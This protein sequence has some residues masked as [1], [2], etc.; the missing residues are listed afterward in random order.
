MNKRRALITGISGFAGSFLAEH[1]L[2]YGWEVM[3]TSP[4]GTWDPWSPGHI[5]DKV[6]LV[7]WDFRDLAGLTS[8]TASA[9]RRFGPTAIFHLAALSIPERC[10]AGEPTAEA[11][12]VNVEG[13][14]QVLHLATELGEQVPVLV[15][16]SSH[17]YGAVS[18]LSP[19]VDELAPLA[20]QTAYAK[21][22]HAVERLALAVAERGY[23]VVI[24][25]AFHHTGPRQRP[26][27]LLPQWAE[28]F[29][30]PTTTE[31]VVY[32]L[33]VWLDLSDVR[34]VVCAYRLLIEGKLTG[35]FNVGSGQAISTRQL[36]ELM[37][38]LSGRNLPVREIRPGPKH[39]PIAC[40][41]RLREATGWQPR[42][43]LEQTVADVL[44]WWKNHWE[45]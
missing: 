27:M 40:I 17:V 14:R 6:P 42:I 24:A 35:V 26:P 19:I 11:W 7:D 21:T 37:V 9:I 18:E 29:A 25:R 16:S 30:R 23:P 5:V 34:D 4:G 32:S 38:Q 1:L 28:Q 39:E 45:S 15:V 31:L 13:T 33:D 10:G 36:Y 41:T 44:E 12:Q 2:E 20:P 43:P 3:G 8:V 22:K